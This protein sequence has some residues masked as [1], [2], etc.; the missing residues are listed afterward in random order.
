MAVL[1]VSPAACQDDLGL[2]DKQYKCGSNEHCASGY[3]CDLRM[4]YCRSESE[5]IPP[6]NLEPVPGLDCERQRLW[7]PQTDAGPQD[8]RAAGP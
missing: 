3:V 7:K 6:E 4:C 2:E 8:L 5:D 1:V